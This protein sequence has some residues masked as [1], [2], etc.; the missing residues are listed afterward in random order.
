M[1]D[2]ANLISLQLKVAELERKLNFVLDHLNVQ[3]TEP[4]Q[5]PAVAEA[6]SWLRQGKKLEA[7]K[8]YQKATG[9]GLKEAKEAVE[10]LEQSLGAA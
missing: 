2:S 3:Y 6:A 9:L 1:D 4:P 10:A 7:I 8:A 5:P